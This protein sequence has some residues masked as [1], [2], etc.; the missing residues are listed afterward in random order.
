M[1]PSVNTAE[2]R[3]REKSATNARPVSPGAPGASASRGSPVP[4]VHHFPLFSLLLTSFPLTPAPSLITPQPPRHT[5]YSAES[6]LRW[7]SIHCPSRLPHQGSYSATKYD[8]AK[9]KQK[10]LHLLLLF[11]TSLPI[12]SQRRGHLFCITC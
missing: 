12:D 11:F 9:L 1:S 5:R 10:Q 3:R 8:F 7:K 6:Q 4:L 2:H